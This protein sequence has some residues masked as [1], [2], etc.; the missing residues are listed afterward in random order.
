SNLTVNESFADY[1]QFLWEE[2]KYGND[3]AAFENWRSMQ[4]YLGGRT[5]ATKDLVRF[6]YADKEDMFDLVSYQKGGRILH[7]LRTYVGDD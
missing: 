4:S 2:Y 1:S 5:D 6:Y 3:A 7:M